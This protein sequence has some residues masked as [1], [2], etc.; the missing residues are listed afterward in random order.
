[1]YVCNL[2]GRFGPKI[3]KY[4]HFVVKGGLVPTFPPPFLAIFKRV[5]LPEFWGSC[6]DLVSCSRPAPAF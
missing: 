5:L 6:L 2:V 3:S 1:M 4:P